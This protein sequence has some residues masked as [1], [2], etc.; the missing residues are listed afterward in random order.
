MLG[1]AYGTGN[2]E[3][4]FSSGINIFMMAVR[5]SMI[6]DKGHFHLAQVAKTW[7][8]CTIL[9]EMTDKGVLRR[10]EQK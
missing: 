10:H 3:E 8:V 5:V 1:K 6:R 7:S 4:R 9:C 2:E